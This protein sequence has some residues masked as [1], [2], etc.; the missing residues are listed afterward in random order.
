MSSTQMV[1]YPQYSHKFL[2]NHIFT[3]PFP[4]QALDL[5]CLQNK[6][7]FENTVGKGEIARNEQ[8]LVFPQCFLLFWITFCYFNQ[9]KNCRLQAFSVWESLGFFVWEKD[10]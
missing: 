2:F 6:F 10:N 9:I 8:F 1:N 7:F 4:K 3:Q 5:T